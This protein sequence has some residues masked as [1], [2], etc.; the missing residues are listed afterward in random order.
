MAYVTGTASTL[1]DL[2]TAVRNACTANGWVLAG[3]VLSKGTCY[4][5]LKTNS[6]WLEVRGGTGKD[7]NNNLTGVTSMWPGQ[8]C[9]SSVVAYP[10]TYF[11]HLFAD[12]DEV[13]VVVN[14]AV[15]FYETLAFGRSA[16]PGLV[17]SGN[18]YCGGLKGTAAPNFDARG[19]T[20]WQ[21]NF[22]SYSLFGGAWSPG[23]G[24]PPWGVDHSLDGASWS[25]EGGFADSSALFWRQPNLWNS[26][27]TL[28]PIR[29]YASRPSGFRS[30]VLE[31]ANARFVAIDNLTDQQIITLG[32]DRWKVYPWFRRGPHGGPINFPANPAPYHTIQFGHA[33][34]YDGP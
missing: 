23:S 16:F 11:I 7:G 34:R 24:L 31:C 3:N 1:T 25:V 5:E 9:V 14:Y 2:L 20:M 22:P 30:P 15:S 27:S 18:W 12:P 8:L 26:E 13:Y 17:G 28:A 4:V 21:T 6:A 19:M 32:S 10:L 33:L 29:V